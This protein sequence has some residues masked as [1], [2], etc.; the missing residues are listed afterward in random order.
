M[1]FLLG[2]EGSGVTLHVMIRQVKY[3]F[4]VFVT[5]RGGVKSDRQ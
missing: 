4:Y 2:R 1:P 3:T 5:N